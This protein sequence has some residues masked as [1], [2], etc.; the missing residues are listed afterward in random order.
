M[1]AFALRR[2]AS[3]AAL[4]LLFPLAGGAQLRTVV[5]SEV[6]VSSREASLHL[7]FQ[8]REGLTIS[9]SHGTV[10]VDSREVGS[11]TRGDDLDVAWRSLLG[12]VLSLDDGPLAA[13]LQAWAPPEDLSGEELE[14]AVEL[15]RA[16]G[17]AL[18]LPQASQ[19]LPSDTE[20]SLTLNEEGSLLEALLKRT[21]ALQGLAEAL[22]EAALESFSIR[23]GEDVE[24]GSG[25]VVE[26]TLIVVDGDLDLR[27][28]VEGDVIVTEGTARLRSGSRIRGDLRVVQGA[29]EAMG[30]RVDGDIIDLDKA[31]LAG[32]DETELEDLREELKQDIRRELRSSGEMRQYSRSASGSFGRLGRMVGELFEKLLTILVLVVLGTFFVHFAGD[33]VDVI[34]TTARRAPAQSAMV[35]MAGG[36]LL[37]PVYILGLL[38][39]AISIIGIPLLLAWAPLFPVAAGLAGVLGYIAVSRNVGEWVAEQEYRGL[40]WIRGSNNF[41]LVATGL[42]ALMLPGLAATLVRFLGLGLGFLAGALSFLGGVAV[43]L[44]VSV[45]FGAV[46]LTR[47]GRIRPYAA[48]Y[49]LEEEDFWDSASSTPDP[50][51]GDHW[52]D[53]AAAESADDEGPEEEEDEGTDDQDPAYR[54]EEDHA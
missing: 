1:S 17:E 26:T 14:V 2:F 32:F 53:A 25:E 38:A 47:G 42:V 12:Q 29:V 39:L 16:L 7:E 41:Y 6:A 31:D 10:L 34:A 27:G 21:G 46:L 13:A 22:E 37:I 23:V 50:E 4:T 40:E 20:I 19:E 43:F 11:Y 44:A 3:A 35:G 48:Y 5:S 18:A 51:G 30:G 15:D 45:G 52:S 49:D 8:D 54:K 36:F 24:I 9:L 28:T 33:R